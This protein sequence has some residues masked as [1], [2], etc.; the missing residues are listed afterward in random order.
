MM[1]APVTLAII[2]PCTDKNALIYFIMQGRKSQAEC[3][4]VGRDQ[5]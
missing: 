5:A 3:G 4:R 1:E 2:L